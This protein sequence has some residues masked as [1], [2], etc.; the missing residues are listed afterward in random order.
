MFSVLSITLSNPFLG[1]RFLY[2]V[3][4][5]PRDSKPSLIKVVVVLTAHLHPRPLFFL[6]RLGL[7]ERVMAGIMFFFSRLSL[8]FP[9]SE[10]ACWLNMVSRETCGNL[11][12]ER[13]G[14]CKG[15][16]L[17]LWNFE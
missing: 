16:F 10:E 13:G 6:Y 11:I 15:Q 14:G 5:C 9:T 4:I 2:S 17:P 8:C 3:Y 7:G 1:N 12:L